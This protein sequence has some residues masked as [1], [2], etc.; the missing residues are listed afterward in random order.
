MDTPFETLDAAVTREPVS[1][2]TQGYGP[3]D[4]AS[5]ELTNGATMGRY[6]VL[7]RVGAG[8]MGTVYLGY[9]P[10][11]DRRVA[12]KL[13]RGGSSPRRRTA[14]LREAQALAKLTHPNVVAVYDVG[15]HDGRVYVA[16]EFIEGVTLRTW[17]QASE[18]SWRE[19]LDMLRLA[20]R[21]LQA[22][23]AQQLIHRDFKPDNVMVSDDGQVRVMDFGLA[24][25][26]SGASADDSGGE[27]V[28]QSSSLLT[29]A[30]A[31]RLAGTPAYMA[32][33]QTLAE[34]LSPAVDQFAFCVSMWEAV[35]R[36]RPFAGDSYAELYSQTSQGR[37]RPPPPHAGMPR[38]LK[39]VL[40]RG[41][42]PDPK[43]R[44][45][46]MADL[47][48]ALDRG[49]R[50]WRWQ[51]ALGVLAVL[52]GAAGALVSR[53]QRKAEAD[54]ALVA[55]CEAEGAAI[56]EVWNE[57]ARQRLRSGLLSTGAGFAAHSVEL[58]LPRLDEYRDAWS[59]GRDE[60]C[61]HGT[62]ERDWD[63]ELQDR[64]AWCFEDRRLQR[65]ATV[66][67]ITTSGPEAARR[68][69]R[70]ASYLDPVHACLDPKL[71][72]RLPMPPPEIRDEI[73]SIRKALSESDGLRHAG[74]FTDALA[75]AQP[76]RER[77]EALKWPPIL[78]SARFIEGRC[79]MAAGQSAGAEAT[80]TQAYFEARDAGSS[81][82]AF[83]AARSLM[84]ALT[85]LERY[86][87]AEIW[88]RHADGL[89]SE[90]DDP[91]G[92]DAAEGHY[93]RIAIYRGMG[94][95]A[96]AAREGELAVRMR[97]TALGAEHPITAAAMRNLAIAYLDLARPREAL[98]LLEG[99]SAIWEDAVGPQHPYIG[100]LAMLR[101]ETLFALGQVDDARAHAEQ[102]LA[103][104]EEVLSPQHPTLSENLDTLGKIYAA[105]GRLDE[106]QQVQ[107]RA[108]ANRRALAGTGHRATA[109]GLLNMSIVDRKRGRYE[110]AAARC[111]EALE[112][113]QIFLEPG[114][115]DIAMAMEYA[116][117][118][119][120]DTGHYDRALQR[121]L[122]AL[123]EREMARG[124][125][126]RQ[127][128]VPL[129]RLGDTYRRVGASAEARQAY[130]RALAIDDRD[131][132]PTDDAGVA[133][134]T[135]LAQLAL[136][137]QEPATALA[138]GE[139]AVRRLRRARTGPRTAGAAHFVLAR[140]LRATDPQGTDA[141]ARGLAQ[142]ALREH[143][144]AYDEAG[145]AAVDAWLNPTP[146]AK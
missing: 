9:D 43:D 30:T 98:D 49:R 96:A 127:L 61:R 26:K 38:W 95:Q 3:R 122:E 105:S 35:C 5:R 109:T 84:I 130:G 103:L 115:P 44:W 55:A 121:R 116:A 72:R 146:D 58:L 92:L 82:V 99:A 125:D 112:I 131:A 124:P 46:S 19:A 107:Q 47:L 4:D 50:R 123:A 141:R 81:E 117:D 143:T 97:T 144:I 27:D 79:L 68:A 21:G 45:P 114:H 29:E 138:F 8:A 31:G 90:L 1:G 77:A 129:V 71:L 80:L 52:A 57:G 64:S 85:N 22:A 100:A 39:R 118:V 135:G 137:A 101:G 145:R 142:H 69:V 126:D 10:E 37:L 17:L 134:L 113:L 110:L 120:A 42:A 88:S 54:Q 108:L 15:E 75:V 70:L 60:A 2:A 12:L 14:L 32:P 34:N 132:D 91:S 139:R 51:V 102:A 40:V 104:H 111:S 59:A 89:A 133:A 63:A 53:Q 128:M 65:E 13:L 48:A 87:E 36:E 62:I 25:P 83:R 74:K 20:G 73:R 67:Q 76:A 56:D 24:R 6:V 7:R 140:A 66:D 136:D 11:L 16:M 119:D 94:D 78:A 18:R 93:L 41:L 106:A 23:H 28:S 33:E 86:H